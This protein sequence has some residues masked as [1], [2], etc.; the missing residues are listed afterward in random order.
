MLRVRPVQFDKKTWDD[1][2]TD[3]TW[4]FGVVK[5]RSLVTVMFSSPSS[6]IHSGGGLNVL[7]SFLTATSPLGVDFQHDRFCL[8]F[9]L[10]CEYIEPWSD[11]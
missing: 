9:Y 1:G 11:Q 4:Q 10:F 2:E 3:R 6:I 8:S 7:L 5:S